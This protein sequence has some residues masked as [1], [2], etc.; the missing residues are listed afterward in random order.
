MRQLTSEKR[1]YKHFLSDEISFF[2]VP[3]SPCR[4]PLLYINSLN[5]AEPTILLQA[6][7]CLQGPPADALALTVPALTCRACGIGVP[8]S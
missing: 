1:S 2:R 4:L 8:R 6:G 5:E 3:Q 7:C